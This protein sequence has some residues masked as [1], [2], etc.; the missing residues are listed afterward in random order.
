MRY[1]R[2]R[3]V[4][5]NAQ[6]I[7]C[8]PRKMTKALTLGASCPLTFGWRGAPEIR[9]VS[10]PPTSRPVEGVRPRHFAEQVEGDFLNH[11]ADDK[12]EQFLGN[13]AYMKGQNLNTFTRYARGCI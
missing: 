5:K 2:G 8:D 13:F 4:L 7:Q 11:P 1:T 3:V 6:Y 9:K 12:M 10:F